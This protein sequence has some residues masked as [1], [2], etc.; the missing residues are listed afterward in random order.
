MKKAI[1]ISLFTILAACTTSTPNKKSAVHHKLDEFATQIPDTLNYKPVYYIPVYSDI[2]S[3]TEHMSI[4]L[5]ITLSIRNA[6]TT[7][8]LYVSHI[9]YYNFKGEKMKDYLS[10]PIMLA[11][12]QSAEVVVQESDKSGGTGASFLVHYEGDTTIK[13]ITQAVMIGTLNQ[14]GI[15][16]LTEGKRI[17]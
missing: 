2:Y 16:Y 4:Q 5:T 6:S 10:Q 17:E 1:Y 11:P 14:Q 3:T 9:E 8:P 13:P 7:A 15:S 12:L